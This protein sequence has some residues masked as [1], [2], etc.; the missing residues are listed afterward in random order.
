MTQYLSITSGKGGVGKSSITVNLAAALTK[1]GFRTA[2]IDADVH[3]FSIPA[4]LGLRLHE[5]ELVQ[6]VDGAIK[7]PE[8]FGIPAISIG[9]FLDKDEPVAWRGP[10]LH[11]TL[12]QF[13]SEVNFGDPD[14]VLLDLPPGTGDM[15]ISVGQLL[16][17]ASSVVITTPQ[18]SASSIAWR[19]ASVLAK[20]GQPIIGIIENMSAATINGVPVDLFGSG[21]GAQLAEQLS[22]ATHTSVPLLGTIPLDPALRLAGDDGEPLIFRDPES[23]AAQAIM[24][25]AEQ[26]S[27]KL[28]SPSGT[29]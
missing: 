20:S 6:K 9:M 15:V 22:D 17:Q 2:I 27:Q 11:R 28:P 3:G 1:Q 19:S 7:P 25:I 4:L 8:P 5:G 12:E 21:G 14:Y 18:P 23:P 29:D 24:Q 16:H 10:M 26:I 13:L